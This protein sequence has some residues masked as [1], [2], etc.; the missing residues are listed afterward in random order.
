MAATEVM[1]HLK[2]F[3]LNEKSLHLLEGRRDLRVRPKKVDQ[4]FFS[5]RE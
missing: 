5:K 4:L 3:E 2:K 1:N